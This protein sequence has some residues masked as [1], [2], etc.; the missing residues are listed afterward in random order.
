M[1][2]PLI[3]P[4]LKMWN[5]TSTALSTL[6]FK[7]MNLTSEQTSLDLSIVPA[8]KLNAAAPFKEMSAEFST[9]NSP[10]TQTEASSFNFHIDEMSKS[11]TGNL[12]S[13]FDSDTV[14]SINATETSFFVFPNATINV[15]VETDFLESSGATESSTSSLLTVVAPEQMSNSSSTQ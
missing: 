5:H 15:S 2:L 13:W 7:V 3:L 9:T 14:P 1:F 8:G 6:N 10:N 4:S 11:Q 12:S